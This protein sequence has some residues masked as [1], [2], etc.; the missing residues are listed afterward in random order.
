MFG[1]CLGWQ[2]I[3]REFMYQGTIRLTT[4]DTSIYIYIVCMNFREGSNVHLPIVVG[5]EFI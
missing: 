3:F 5:H 4:R 2:G 1:F